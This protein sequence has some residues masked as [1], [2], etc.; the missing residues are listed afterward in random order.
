MGVQGKILPILCR[1][2]LC[3]TPVALPRGVVVAGWPSGVEHHLAGESPYLV[4]RT[5]TF[6]AQAM[7]DR[8]LGAK[9]PCPTGIDPYQFRAKVA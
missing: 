5:A 2:D 4:A 8:I 7:A 3:S 1:P 9:S 6:M